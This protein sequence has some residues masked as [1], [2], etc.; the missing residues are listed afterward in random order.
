MTCFP[1]LFRVPAVARLT[2]NLEESE[3]RHTRP[4][5]DGREVLREAWLV[6]G[7]ES[8]VVGFGFRLSDRI[9][10]IG[11]SR[12]EAFIFNAKPQ[13]KPSALSL[14]FEK[15]EPRTLRVFKQR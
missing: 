2:E 1:M 6:E 4:Q 10:Q 12:S 9:S 7:R 5:L 15:S 11:I 14:K 13:V 3:V 8:S